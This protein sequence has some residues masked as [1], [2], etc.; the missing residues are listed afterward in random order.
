MNKTIVIN[1]ERCLA[2]K[3]CELACAIAHS[4]SGRLEDAINEQ[5]RPQSRVTVEISDEMAVPIQCRHCEDAPCMKIC[6][7]GAIYRTNPESPVLINENLCIGCKFCML[8][9][10]FGVID[11]AADGKAVTKCDLCITRRGAETGPACV[12]ACSTGALEFCD[13]KDFSKQRR[14]LAAAGAV[15]HIR[16]ADV[17]SETK[18][19]SK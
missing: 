10:P 1:V 13:L 19:G 16:N 3:N 11:I 8:V 9:C 18:D 5:P 4:K 12:Q 2:C 14:N 17:I 6:P 15:S 7:T